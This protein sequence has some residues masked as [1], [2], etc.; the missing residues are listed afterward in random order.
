VRDL[1]EGVTLT[2]CSEFRGETQW[3]QHERV[4]ESNESN[5]QNFEGPK[6]Q[7]ERQCKRCE[8]EGR[9]KVQCDPIETQFV[10]LETRGDDECIT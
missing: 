2:T 8:E 4:T 1:E 3:V 6:G 7:E 5:I 10:T 9:G